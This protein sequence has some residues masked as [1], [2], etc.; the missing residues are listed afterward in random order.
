MIKTLAFLRAFSGALLTAAALAGCTSAPNCDKPNDAPYLKAEDLAALKVPSD[1]AQPDRATGLTIPP[2]SKNAQAADSTCL[3]RVPSY[4][5]TAGR[6]A[7]SPE[8][9]VADWGQAW[10]D[11]N[12]EAVVAMYSDKLQTDPSSDKATW[13][14]QRRTEVAAGPLPNARLESVKISAAGTDRQ[15][16]KF[17]Q[18]FGTNAVQKELTLIRE[19]GVWKILAERVIT[20]TQS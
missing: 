1:L 3:D 7:A 6:L 9:M 12:S 11:R 2:P 15:L 10:A 19:N 16:A 20:A 14:A 5:G 8:E 4:F 13:L 18:R 17:V